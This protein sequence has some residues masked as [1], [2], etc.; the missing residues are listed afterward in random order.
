M[1]DYWKSQPRKFCQYCKCWI[2]DNKPSVEFHERGKNHKENVAAKIQEIKKKSVAKAKQEQKMSKDFAAMEEAALKA[3]EEDLKRLAGH[4]SGES[5]CSAKAPAEAPV[6][7]QKKLKPSSVKPRSDPSSSSSSRTQAW[8]SGTT[9]DGLLYYYNTLTAESQ[10]EKP[11]GFVDECVSSTAGQTQ[12]SSGSAWMEAVSPDGFTYYYNTESGE[13]SWEKPE[14]LSSDEVSPPGVDSP[15]KETESAALDDSCPAQPEHTPEETAAD[16]AEAD[17]NTQS[18][19]PKISFRKR[20]EEP[21]QTPA[22][23]GEQQSSDD[24]A[25][26]EQKQEDSGVTEAAVEVEKAA[27]VVEEV[28]P[29]KRARTTNPY[30]AWEQIQ[31]QPDPYESVDLQLPQVEV[32]V[33]SPAAAPQT[34]PRSFKER[35]ISSLGA[36][37]SAGASFRKRKT[38]NGKP[39]SL[40]QR[41][42]DD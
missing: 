9:A 12:E 25:S 31:T 33:Q 34:S 40:R 38:E 11:D 24:G 3:Y 27:V 20:K 16:K 26:G 19:G 29:V 23:G 1:A 36:D 42:Q 4:T 8:V 6:K 41:A 21:T 35:S 17:D 30:G 2:A 5:V 32:C 28:R 18:S 10:W 14:E 39:R 13:S 15:R 7:K 22:D 37:S